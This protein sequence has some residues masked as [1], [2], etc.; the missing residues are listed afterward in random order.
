MKLVTYM[1]Q[2]TVRLGA[3]IDGNVVDLA[4]AYADCL[5]CINPDAPPDEFPKDMLTLLQ[6]GWDSW[7]ALVATVEYAEA[8]S[9][10][11]FIYAMTD[12]QLGP[13]LDN[14]SKII[15]IGLNYHDH[16]REKGTAVPERP[17]L[18]SKFPTTITGPE[19][20]ITWPTDVSQEVDYEAELALVIGRKGRN[21]PPDRALDYVAG[22]MI[23][24]DVSA[25][26]VQFSDKQWVRGKSFDTFCPIGPYLLTADEVDDPHNLGIRC[27]VNGEL[28][29]DSNTS[30]LIF[31]IPELLAFISRT[32]TLLPGDIISTGTPDGVGVYRDPQV[33]LKSGDVVEIEIDELG[34]LRNTV[35]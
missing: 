1:H 34:R 23:A 9:E 17:L 24:N 4:R 32:S 12:V 6:G 33:F 15:C 14:P 21:I 19:T 13:P 7:Q 26:N 5:S 3:I 31:K 11:D 2:E 29:Q 10:A 18:F 22:Y 8:L 28:R 25:R 30:E 35:K 16:C 20:E 27:W